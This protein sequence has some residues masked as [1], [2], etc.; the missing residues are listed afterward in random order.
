MKYIDFHS[1]ILPGMD[2]GAKDLSTAVRMISL[3]K[4]QGV[5]TIIATSHYI[6]HRE[7]PTA[8]AER[9]L[10][11]YEALQQALDSCQMPRILLGAEIYL[12]KGVA[13]RDLSALT[14]EGTNAILLE[15]PRERY[16]EWIL[17]EI[18]DIIYSMKVTP[19]MAHIE[20]YAPHYRRSELEEILSIDGVVLQMNTAAFGER[21]EMKLAQQ[22][23]QLGLPLVFGSDAHNLADRAPRWDLLTEKISKKPKLQPLIQ[24]AAETAAELL[25]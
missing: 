18:E 4:E 16:Q 6:P 23:D 1:H 9:R 8:F 13:E 15:L 22:L 14:I 25:G 5:E 7:S 10:R 20:R 3:L 24:N 12:E 11:A 17:R 2:D 21:G 19:I